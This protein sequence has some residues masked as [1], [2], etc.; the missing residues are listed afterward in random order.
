M[1]DDKI[2][3]EDYFKKYKINPNIERS[4]LTD[5]MAKQILLKAAEALNER[6]DQIAVIESVKDG[7]YEVFK[8]LKT[9]GLIASLFA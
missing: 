6:K 8:I 2:S 9:A 7:A 5:E 1:A 4:D 3:A